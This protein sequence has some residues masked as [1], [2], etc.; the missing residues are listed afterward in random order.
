MKLSK[1]LLKQIN[2][3]QLS[4]EQQDIINNA[5]K[6]IENNEVDNTDN[7]EE[8]SYI[9]YSNDINVEELDYYLEQVE[10]LGT[11]QIEILELDNEFKSLLQ[12]WLNSMGF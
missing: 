9:L 3:L 6:D 1:E 11:A 10:H 7:I 4:Q 12:D 8:A 2:D 5:I